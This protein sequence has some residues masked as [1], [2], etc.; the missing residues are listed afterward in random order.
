MLSSYRG[1]LAHPG[2][3]AFSLTGLVARL[4]I[5]MAGLGIVLLVAGETGSYGQAG[6]VSAAYM[7]ANA[8]L[9]ITAVVTLVLALKLFGAF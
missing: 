4:P 3:L 2:A 7:V 1:V 6:A 5:S 8:V 9:A